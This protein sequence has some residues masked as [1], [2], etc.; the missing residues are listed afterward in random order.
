MTG[1]ELANRQFKR[2][3]KR[4]LIADFLTTSNLLLR[5]TKRATTEFIALAG[6]S[7]STESSLFRQAEVHPH[8][9]VIGPAT[10]SA[11]NRYIDDTNGVAIRCPCS[12]A[13]AN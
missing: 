1:N 5:L 10:P 3:S 6:F 11:L 7:E 8:G 12:Q 4:S 13:T 2:H 9:L